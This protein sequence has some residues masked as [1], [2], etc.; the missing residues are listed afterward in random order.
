MSRRERERE[1]CFSLIRWGCSLGKL[2][3]QFHTNSSLAGQENWIELFFCMARQTTSAFRGRTRAHTTGL[4]G[5]HVGLARSSRSS[6]GAKTGAF[7]PCPPF[8]LTPKDTP[9]SVRV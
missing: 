8:V 3:T 9:T 5:S 1:R 4:A 7:A 2:I 6:N